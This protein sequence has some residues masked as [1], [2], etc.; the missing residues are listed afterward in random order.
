[1]KIGIL[2]QP[3]IANYGGVLQNFALQYKLKEFGFDVITVN[4]M[5]DKP[6]RFRRFLS[7]AKNETY[8]RLTGN[9]RMIY[10]GQQIESFRLNSKQFINKNIKV[11]QDLH[12][13]SELKNFINLNKID[14]LIVGSDQVWRP[15]YSPNIY[16]YFLD[17]A[18]DNDNIKKIAYAASFGT[19]EWEFDITQTRLSKELIKKFDAIS[20]REDTGLKLCKQYFDLDVTHVLDPT[21]LLT[22]E[23]YFKLLDVNDLENKEGLFTYV[24]DKDDKKEDFILNIGNELNL[25]RF[26]NQPKNDYLTDKSD[27]LDDFVFPKVEGWL[28]S[29]YNADF[30]ITDSFHGTVFSIL[31]NKPF[32][33]IVNLDR[34]ASRFYSLL[35]L[36]NLEDRLVSDINNFDLLLLQNKINYKEVNLKLNELRAK[37]NNFIKDYLK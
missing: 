33:S 5:Y 8:N 31:F 13:P 14:A 37:S 23:D 36:F 1:M 27:N 10:T 20:V 6:S 3:L 24:L 18:Y 28:A 16:N 26:T 32:L 19:D 4:R 7:W 29:F 22:K 12:N 17:F 34:G 15:K 9:H 11:S 2:T 25:K 21:L 30:I 35:K